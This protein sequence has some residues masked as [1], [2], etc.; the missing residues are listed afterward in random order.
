MTSLDPARPS[1]PPAA[2]VDALDEALLKYGP[3]TT[4]YLIRHAQQDYPRAGSSAADIVDPP[5]SGVGER[6]LEHLA[7][8]FVEVPLDAVYASPLS[9]ALRTGQAAGS[10][11]GL[12]PALDRD[13]REFD[14]FYQLPGDVPPEVSLGE[15]VLE[16]ARTQMVRDLRWDA[17]PASETSAQFRG[18]VNAAIDRIVAAH[19]NQS[20]AVACH[21]GAIN[22]L[23]A[24]RLGITEDMFFRAAHT[25]VTT[26]Y[27]SGDRM[28]IHGL[29]DY[30]HLRDEPE[31]RTA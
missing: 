24:S 8:R 4:L 10:H 7:K 18:R 6:Q 3:R 1:A 19:E 13:L 30:T 27:I 15:E 11:L 28:V 21:G 26:V 9:R 16:A 12:K 22:A 31:L 17:Y 14:I 2:P 20:I 25:S 23:L 29:N 5:L